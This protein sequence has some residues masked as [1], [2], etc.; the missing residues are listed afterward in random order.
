M[1]SNRSMRRLC[2]VSARSLR[3]PGTLYQENLSSSCRDRS[4]PD[5]GVARCSRPSQL[6][7]AMLSFFPFVYGLFSGIRRKSIYALPMLCTLGFLLLAAL[8]YRYFFPFAP[9]QDFRQSVLLLFP[10]AYFI[11]QGCQS[12]RI[13]ILLYPAILL[14]C[15]GNIAFIFLL[16]WYR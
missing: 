13:K 8:L 4:F 6:L 5:A 10:I 2:D 16:F 1:I 11:A 7:T 14:C 12:T 9:N 3:F 15:A